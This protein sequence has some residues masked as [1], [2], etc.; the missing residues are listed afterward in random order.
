MQPSLNLSSSDEREKYVRAYAIE[1]ARGISG[2]IVDAVLNRTEAKVQDLSL[3]PQAEEF[4]ER[5]VLYRNN[6]PRKVRE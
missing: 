4:I 1:T 6:S 2:T 5:L 3:I